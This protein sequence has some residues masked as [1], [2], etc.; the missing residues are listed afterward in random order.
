[1]D[2]AVYVLTHWRIV[3]RKTRHGADFA[4]LCGYVF[5][6][7]RFPP[8]EYVQISAVC[9]HRIQFDTLVL[10][11]LKG[12][13]YW[14]GRP[15]PAESAANHQLMEYLREKQSRL[16]LPDRDAETQPQ[17]G[18]A[19]PPKPPPD[20]AELLSQAFHLPR[21][22]A[23]DF[24]ATAPAVA[25]N[26]LPPDVEVEVPAPALRLADAARR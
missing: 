26:D 4:A 8:G 5:G 25:C 13:E 18:R 23:A 22:R 15:D 2:V 19:A 14:L 24:P 17:G 1:M 6:N 21:R 16:V 20:I 10:V 3:A 11:T 9:E 7:P 12:S